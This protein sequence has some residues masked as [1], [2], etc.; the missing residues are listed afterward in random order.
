MQAQHQLI[1]NA[2]RERL[3]NLAYQV[4]EVAERPEQAQKARQWQ[5]H[6]DLEAGPPLI[7]IDPENGWYE[8]I[9]DEQLECTSPLAR[10]WERTLV[11]E[12]FWANELRDDRV[13]ERY[14]DVAY[15]FTNTGWGMK[16]VRHEIRDGGAYSWEAPIR[17]WE[18][19]FPK[20]KAQQIIVD[21]DASSAHL[22]AAQDAFGDLLTVRQ[23]NPWW[24]TLGMTWD[25]INLR[26]LTTY[27]VDL[28]D[29]PE[30][31]HKLMAHLR[32][33][34]LAMLDSLEERG[35]LPLNLAGT[36]VGSGGFGWTSQ[37][38]AADYDGEHVRTRDMWGFAESQETSG[39]A[40]AMFEEFVFPYQEPIL[41]RFG[42]NCY[43]C[44]E[45]LE[46]RWQIIKRFPRLRR[47]SCSP[48]ADRSAMSE[49]LGGEYVMSLK[50]SP[51]PLSQ[52]PMD[53]DTAR[54]ELR[55]DLEIT[56]ENIVE[57]VM[58]DTHT[59]GGGPENAIRWVQIAREEIARVHGG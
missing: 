23:R 40:P 47:I 17:E 16:E 54:A 26:G 19:D 32:D 25:I 1:G 10:S 46:N 59:L 35:L 24:W 21:Y 34:H 37:L 51:M 12:L 31:I 30:W 27:L 45:P 50:P 4:A 38:P 56:R 22:E 53:E 52:R 9:R 43:G 11:K 48:W 5:A 15:V 36:Y 28:Y 6:N 33:S 18:R 8:I 55:R 29:N 20:L 14:F 41:D 44:C 49:H 7:F 39:I 2:D 42:L 57:L 3:R 58:K 13:T